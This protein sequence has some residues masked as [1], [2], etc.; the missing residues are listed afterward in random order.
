MVPRGTKCPGARRYCDGSGHCTTSIGSVGA[1]LSAPALSGLGEGTFADATTFLY[2]PN[3]PNAVQVKQ[4]DAVPIVIDS[5]RQ[6]VIRGRVLGQDGLP[7]SQAKI[8]IKDRPQYGQTYSRTDGWYDL[9]VEGG[10]GLIV[11][12]TKSG[13]MPLQRQVQ[14][15]WN[16]YAPMDDVVMDK[17]Q[18]TT[19]QAIPISMMTSPVVHVGPTNTAPDG[20]QPRGAIVVFP[21]GVTLNT[22]STIQ[23]PA[24]NLSFRTH[25]YTRDIN[26]AG[27]LLQDSS[28]V[29]VTAPTGMSVPTGRLAMPGELP[30]AS[31]YTYAIDL[32]DDSQLGDDSLSISFCGADPTQCTGVKPALYVDN[33]LNMKVG[34]VVPVGS[35]NKNTA[36]WSAEANGLVVNLIA[37]G[38][39]SV[40]FDID[41][42]QPGGNPGAESVDVVK[43]A[44][45]LPATADGT[46]TYQQELQALQNLT[47]GANPRLT[48]PVKLWRASIAHLSAWDLNF[49]YAPK[50]CNDTPS[51][52]CP[53]DS[54]GSATVGG[55]GSSKIKECEQRGSRIFCDSHSVGEQIPIPGAGFSLVCGSDRV[56][57][58][59]AERKVHIE[60]PS[61]NNDAVHPKDRI[62]ISAD[63]FA[64][65]Q[66]LGTASAGQGTQNSFD[67][68]PLSP[69]DAYGR[70]LNGTFDATI[71]VTEWYRVYQLQ[72]AATANNHNPAF[73]APVD[74]Q[75]SDPDRDV[76][77]I[78]HTFKQ[79]LSFVD[80]RMSGLGGWD[81]SIHHWYDASS[82]TLYRGDG[83][84]VRADSFASNAYMVDQPIRG[85]ALAQNDCNVTPGTPASQF[86]A[87]ANSDI[88]IAP[89]GDIFL[90]NYS[91]GCVYSLSKRNNCNTDEP[92]SMLVAGAV[93]GTTTTASGPIATAVSATSVRFSQP[94]QAISV[95]PDGSLYIGEASQYGVMKPGVYVHRVY[96]DTT[97]PQDKT[98]ISASS[99]IQTIAGTASGTISGDYGRASDASFGV[100]GYLDLDVGK[101]GTV[102]VISSDYSSSQNYC[103][104]LRSITQDTPYPTI[105][106]LIGG[107]ATPLVDESGP[108]TPTAG[109]SF[110]CF[111]APDPHIAVT[112][113]GDVY[114]AGHYNGSV[115]HRD[116]RMEHL[117]TAATGTG[118]VPKDGVLATAA[119]AFFGSGIINFL[120]IAA[121][122]DGSLI[123]G[124][125]GE[126]TRVRRVN[127]SGIISTVVNGSE[128]FNPQSQS[129]SAYLVS[130]DAHHLSVPALRVGDFRDLPAQ[131][132][133]VAVAPNGNIYMAET[134]TTGGAPSVL[135][136]YQPVVPTPGCSAYVPS[137]DAS[138]IYCFDQSGYHQQTLDGRLMSNGS[139]LVK[140]K[141][142]Y[143][144]NKLT[145]V[146]DTDGNVTYINPT[147]DGNVQILPPN[148]GSLTPTTI[149]VDSNKY[150]ERV[151]TPD[152]AQWQISMSNTGLLQSLQEPSRTTH[153]FTYNSL[154]ELLTDG[155]Q[156]PDAVSVAFYQS[157]DFT[158]QT[159]SAT[160]GNSTT[161]TTTHTSATGLKTTYAF[162]SDSGGVDTRTVTLPTTEVYQTTA[163]ADGATKTTM[164]DG[165]TLE[166]IPDNT[167][168]LFP[169]L[170]QLPLRRITLPTGDSTQTR[171]METRVTRDPSVLDASGNDKYTVTTGANGSLITTYV[172][173][174]SSN[175]LV[176]ATPA[177]RQYTTTFDGS[178]HVVS[179]QEYGVSQY[180][181]FGYTQVGG[182]LN[183]VNNLG[184]S[185]TLGY[186]ENGNPPGYLSSITP[187]SPT[188]RTTFDWTLGSGVTQLTQ[189]T[190]AQSTII[191]WDA[192]NDK[193]EPDDTQYPHAYRGF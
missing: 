173:T 71:Q 16:E 58:F 144:A 41:S 149:Y 121:A 134:P 143:D 20:S 47:G 165:T 17:P 65:G 108:A 186:G 34:S 59:S 50:K 3:N 166:T 89:N 193:I 116:G 119:G 117:W 99:V 187:P 189:T 37:T 170:V 85:N 128:N 164:P 132:G 142:E 140:Y 12:F 40:G 29:P 25:E 43:K 181:T 18:E 158:T 147:T 57:G 126:S 44:F 75:S 52:P 94:I 55:H 38:G 172:Y 5:N 66:R 163:Q 51:G 8:T 93:S 13:Y 161:R 113:S 188:A 49:G 148:W 67:I 103:V 133:P 167:D 169:G 19:G 156:P 81:L 157:L 9:A 24:A 159:N 176:T 123:I 137:E 74:T 10:G 62:M 192:V 23:S 28:S 45:G 92:C 102:Y 73:A 7:L 30:P 180:P 70:A 90:S 32:F 97:D 72:A 151:Q 14:M 114:I 178:G 179:I 91:P 190:S 155:I 136:A 64:G 104:R 76:L 101:D 120:S 135:R 36:T 130:F 110:S 153:V 129:N 154:G 122:S 191:T 2:D 183:L 68:I 79:K 131:P 15:A 88:A 61:Q 63:V 80:S 33:F 21:T 168:P 150:A 98:R 171:T 48:P 100:S 109:T 6:S 174:P 184:G 162:T 27:T 106:P 53:D 31:G 87:A 107:G 83:S 22:T 111:T 42:D 146:T 96:P 152:G 26:P 139:R 145:K 35:Y 185:T 11:N 39:G 82:Q 141:F 46:N 69:T 78:R 160:T 105:H 118:N 84:R 56:P 1:S 4:S 182:L 77:K 175:T 124:E 177:G 60:L 112:P 54:P 86:G 138:E 127:P 95:G 115:L 125:Q